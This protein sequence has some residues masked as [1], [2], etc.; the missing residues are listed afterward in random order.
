MRCG[1]RTLR[2]SGG[3]RRCRGAGGCGF[4]GRWGASGGL[5]NDGWGWPGWG[6]CAGACWSSA[7]RFRRHGPRRWAG[8]SSWPR[9][10]GHG[11]RRLRSCR[12][13][14]RG[15]GCGFCGSGCSW[16]G[17]SGRGRFGGSRS[18]SCRR[19][20]RACGGGNNRFGGYGLCRCSWCRGCGRLG[21]LRGCCHDWCRRGRGFLHRQDCFLRRGSR[22]CGCL[23]AIATGLD[24]VANAGCLVVADGAAVALRG[25]RELLG[26]IEHILVLKAQVLG[27]LVNPD[28]AAAGHSV[29][30]RVGATG[31][32]GPPHT[33]RPTF[34]LPQSLQKRWRAGAAPMPRRWNL[35]PGNAGPSAVSCGA[36]L[37]RDSSGLGKG[38]PIGPC[39]FRERVL[40][41]PG[42]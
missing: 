31:A 42:G 10:W 2:R 34:I 15:R 7:G 18:G 19:G 11:L 14:A 27:Q 9:R 32:T 41:P 33:V 8:R 17:S 23:G 5:R 29:L 36:W 28:F 4:A 13:G 38:R 1:G 37:P 40:H 35:Q 30:Q 12:G 20:G 22:R 3:T 21:S 25:D 6:G 39:P 16:F 26:G 24:Q